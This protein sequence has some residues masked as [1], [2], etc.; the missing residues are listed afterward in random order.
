[1]LPREFDVSGKTVIITGAARGIGKGIARVLAHAGARVMVTALTE[2]YLAPLGRGMQE[3]GYPILTITAD[4]TDSDDWQRVTDYA[5]SEWGHIDALV[6]NLG[7]AIRKPLLPTPGSDGT[8]ITDDEYRFVLDVNLTQAFKGC[9]A[10]GPHMIERGRG[11]VINISGFAARRG[12]PEALVYSTAKAGVARLTQTL[13]LEWAP[14]GITVNC[15]APGIF[16][17]PETADPEQLANSRQNAREN[18][19]LG[20]VGELAEVGF[21]TLYLMSDASS[22]MTGETLYIDGGLSHS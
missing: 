20:R 21:L 12:S 22:Y 14:Y 2:T 9:R 15:I 1:M 5:L 8:P 19:P 6:N 3:A 17:D 4:A 7:D 11:R 18:V 10:V 16:P 13:A